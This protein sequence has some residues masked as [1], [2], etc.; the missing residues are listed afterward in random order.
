LINEFV[1]FLDPLTIIGKFGTGGIP[2]LDR[3][4]FNIEVPVQ[5]T[6]G[7]GYWVGEGKPRPLTRFSFENI[8]LRWNTVGNIAVLTKKLIAN[9]SGQ[10][11]LR[12]RNALAK[13]LIRRIDLT[14]IDPAVGAQTDI[15][16]ASF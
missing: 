8:T 9:S 11:E 14:V 5:L 2:S 6:G 16:P 12:V 3:V 10:A 7:D 1:E 15:R 4:P 13:A